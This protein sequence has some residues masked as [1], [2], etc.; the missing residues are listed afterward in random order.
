MITIVGWFL[1]V[2]WV[3][4]FV[5]MFVVL[6]LWPRVKKLLP[7]KPRDD[8]R[9]FDTR[10]SETWGDSVKW[11]N[12]EQKRVYGWTS[13]R[14][15]VGDVLK[16]EMRSGKIG[17]FVFVE[18]ETFHDPEDMFFGNVRFVRYEEAPPS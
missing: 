7:A 8:A 1:I 3:L 10:G 12:V 18:V 15:R 9:T 14:P 2:F 16:S 17:V 6:P 11:W 5:G 4:F 13:P